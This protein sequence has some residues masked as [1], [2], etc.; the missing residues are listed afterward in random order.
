MLVVI[1]RTVRRSIDFFLSVNIVRDMLY[2]NYV[3]KYKRRF[4]GF[5]KSSREEVC[6]ACGI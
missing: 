6:Y 4:E 5:K 1:E 2:L 3:F